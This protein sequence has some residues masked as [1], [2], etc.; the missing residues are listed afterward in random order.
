MT[1]TRKAFPLRD[2]IIVTASGTIDL[3]A[4]KATLKSLAADPDYKANYE[5]LLD[6]R[7]SKCIMSLM[8]VFEIATYLAW[9]DP[10]L[11]PRQKIAVLVSGHGAFDH[12]KFLEM[13]STNRGIKLGAFEDY[14]KA[15]EW[16]DADLPN[17]PKETD[18]MS[19]Q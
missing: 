19:E 4:S 16:L 3:A 18:A 14:E 10:A 11:P 17:D 8:D 7:D 9:P 15:S 6:L 2:L 1:S 5:I 13:C 12:A